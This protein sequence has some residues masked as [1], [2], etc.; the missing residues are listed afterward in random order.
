MHIILLII[1]KQENIME[2]EHA[3]ELFDKIEERTIYILEVTE[4]LKLISDA[5]VVKD[6]AEYLY[7]LTD[8]LHNE[9]DRLD[10]ERAQLKMACLD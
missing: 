3:K 10:F 8:I 7:I 9:C 4:L 2:R 1:H 6:T 5:S